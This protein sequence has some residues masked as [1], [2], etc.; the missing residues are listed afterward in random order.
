M[1]TGEEITKGMSTLYD[2]INQ[3]IEEVRTTVYRTT[4]ITMVTA[5]WHIGDLFCVPKRIRPS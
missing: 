2:T 1:A 3:I 5:Y 4:N